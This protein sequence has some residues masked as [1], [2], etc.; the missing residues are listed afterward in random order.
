MT[1]RSF[2]RSVLEYGF[3]S[4]RLMNIA[5]PTVFIAWAVMCYGIPELLGMTR[6]PLMTTATLLGFALILPLVEEIT[7]WTNSRILKT[8]C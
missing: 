8:Q 2:T 7:K 5:L 1:A 3:F 6:L 4:N